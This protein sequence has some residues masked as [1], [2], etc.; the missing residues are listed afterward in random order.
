MTFSA[1]TNNWARNGGTAPL[2]LPDQPVPDAAVEPA[3]EAADEAPAEEA[4]K[5]R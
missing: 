4:E 2:K 3:L 1:S 5:P